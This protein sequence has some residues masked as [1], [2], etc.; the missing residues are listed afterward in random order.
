MKT[1]VVAV[2]LVVVVVAVVVFVVFEGAR[3]CNS[4]WLF[5]CCA[6]EVPPLL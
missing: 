6:P 1:D 4:I 5:R 3:S 2:F